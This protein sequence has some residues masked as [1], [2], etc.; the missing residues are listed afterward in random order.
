M[1]FIIQSAILKAIRHD[2]KKTLREVAKETKIDFTRLQRLETGKYEL[3]IGEAHILGHFFKFDIFK[4]LKEFYLKDLE[5][6][7]GALTIRR[8]ARPEA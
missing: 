3:T 4:A 1:I 2:N 7:K 6:K 5:D 8:K